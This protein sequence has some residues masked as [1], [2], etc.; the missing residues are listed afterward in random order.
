M[1]EDGE[2]C[3]KINNAA[4]N[5]VVEVP[6]R[7][8]GI[9]GVSTDVHESI[10]MTG[11]CYYGLYEQGEGHVGGKKPKGWEALYVAEVPSLRR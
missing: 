5:G 11:Y 1:G 7:N 9:L 3:F 8:E 10:A 4:M 2:H 6:P